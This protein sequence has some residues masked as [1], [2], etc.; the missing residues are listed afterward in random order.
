MTTMTIDEILAEVRASFQGDEGL[1]IPE[2][3]AKMGVSDITARKRVKVL[4]GAGKM[5]MG[6]SLRTGMDGRTFPHPVYR[7]L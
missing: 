3:A 7:V 5:K 2:W 6:K 4:I 1:T